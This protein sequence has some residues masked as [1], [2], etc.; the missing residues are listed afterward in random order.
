MTSIYGSYYPV[1]VPKM[2]NEIQVLK[3]DRQQLLEL[4]ETLRED[5]NMVLSMQSRKVPT[6]ELITSC[7]GD[8][9]STL[10]Q[11]GMSN[12]SHKGK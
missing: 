8:I 4:L 6:E 9:E 2:I 12:D 10:I 11:F 5:L 3:Q 7:L 1:S